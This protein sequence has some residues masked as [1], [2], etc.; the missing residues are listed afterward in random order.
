VS[1]ELSRTHA[2]AHHGLC[3]QL[4]YR[5]ASRSI[6][7]NTARSF[8][9]SSQSISNSPKVRC[10]GV[11]PERADRVRSVEVR[12]AEDLDQLGRAAGGRA[13]NRLRSSAS[14]SSKV[15]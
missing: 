8:R 4:L 14:T 13:S 15:T 12:E 11:P 6:P 3:T 2:A 5:C 1:G 7:T 10:L 9:S